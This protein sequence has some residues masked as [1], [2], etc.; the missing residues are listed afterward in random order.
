MSIDQLKT[1]V[2]HSIGMIK[3]RIGMNRFYPEPKSGIAK[4]FSTVLNGVGKMLG[5]SVGAFSEIDPGY[6][7]L[8]EQ[9]MEVQKQMQLVSLYSNIEKSKHETN[10]AAV[11]NVRAA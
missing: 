6:R 1:S 5:G 10:M 2:D 9:Q 4:T 8:I 3:Q 11:R 7:E